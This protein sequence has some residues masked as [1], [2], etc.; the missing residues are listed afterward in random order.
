MSIQP[1]GVR[2]R[3][4]GSVAPTHRVHRDYRFSQETL[5]H[6]AQGRALRSSAPDETAFVEQA[7][8]HYV[9]FLEGAIQSQAQLIWE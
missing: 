6:I 5:G 2:G 3:P 1:L 9:T 8:A 7:I 4:R